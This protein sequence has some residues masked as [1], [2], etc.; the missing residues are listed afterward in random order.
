MDRKE[1]RRRKEV[2]E[3]MK[4]SGG[5]KF[6]NLVFILAIFFSAVSI[7]KVGAQTKERQKH[8]TKGLP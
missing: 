8:F 5:K 4:F 3:M 2:S 6:W 7:Q 1:K